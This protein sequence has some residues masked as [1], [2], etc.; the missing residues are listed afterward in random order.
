[1]QSKLYEK[2][3]MLGSFIEFDNFD[4]VKGKLS[5]DHEQ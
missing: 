3:I 2:Q 5:Y 4:I 1:M